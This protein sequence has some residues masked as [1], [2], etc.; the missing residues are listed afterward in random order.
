MNENVV[1]Q[2]FCSFSISSMGMITNS[3]K[4]INEIK[5]SNKPSLNFRFLLFKFRSCKFFS[6]FLN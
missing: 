3:A 4:K 6:A 1:N 5:T 2:I